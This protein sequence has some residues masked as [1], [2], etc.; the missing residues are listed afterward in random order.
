MAAVPLRA[1]RQPQQVLVRRQRRVAVLQTEQEQQAAQE[2]SQTEQRQEP[3]N[4]VWVSS[5]ALKIDKQTG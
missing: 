4:Q 5:Q 3:Q 1:M 2:D